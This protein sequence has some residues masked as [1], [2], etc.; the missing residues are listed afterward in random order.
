MRRFAKSRCPWLCPI[1]GILAADVLTFGA[2]RHVLVP[3]HGV[4]PDVAVESSGR[5]DLV[6]G[7]GRN[8]FFSAS[9][10]GGRTF[11]RPVQLNAA[12]DTVLAFRERGPKIA[13]GQNGT[14]HVVWMDPGNGRLEYARST[15]GGRSFSPPRNLRDPGAHLDEATVAADRAG[16]VLVVW[17]D[18]R[19]GADPANP[20]SLPI[21]AAISR[22]NG[23]TF[24]KNEMIRHDR[25]PIRACSCC[26]LKA[27]AEGKGVFAVAFRGAYHNIRDEYVARV[28]ASNGARAWSLERVAD[29]EW[30]FEGCPMSGPFLEL[31]SSPARLWVAWMNQGRVYYAPS[32]DGG[33]HFGAP[34]PAAVPDAGVENHPIVL[35]NQRGEIFFAWEDGTQIR[36]QI[37]GRTGRLSRSGVAGPL[38]DRSK[39]TGFVDG[40]G[41]F[42][43][44]F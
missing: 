27:V 43:L 44:V 40:Q 34:R 8:A 19:L 17:L 3:D 37:T 32:A 25:P 24:S 28:S 12:P 18:S 11:T 14:L 31:A 21:F 15:D 33:R 9:N 41:N 42:C 30:H 1:I 22:D 35:V 10:D 23:A 5:V 4:A 38:P 39:A 16:N 13:A 20:L 7:R 6:F 36:W 29:Q 26:A 2:V